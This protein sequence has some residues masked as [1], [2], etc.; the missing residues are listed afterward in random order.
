MTRRRSSVLHRS[1]VL[2]MGLLLVLAGCQP[3]PAAPAGSSQAQK[4]EV[5]VKPAAPAAPA[6]PAKEKVLV[7]AQPGDVT[8]MDANMHNNGPS[9]NVHMNIFDWVVVRMPDGSIQP[10]L[11]ES[12]EN[13]DPLTWV[14]KIRK[15]VKFHNGF[16]LTAED[17]K[18]T[19]ERI[20]DPANKSPRASNW[21]QVDKI[22][23]P[24]PYTFV[25][26]TKAPYALTLARMSGSFDVV[27]KRYHEEAGAQK[28][29]D[30]PIGTGPY[31]FKEWIKDQQVVL[32]AFDGY[33]RG[34]P[35]IDRIVFRPIPEASTRIAELLSG[36][37]HLAYDLTMDQAKDL[38]RRQGV[39]SVIGPSTRIE[40]VALDNTKETPLK[41]VRV[42]Q[43]LNY[44]VDKEG[45]LKA[46]FEGQG[47]AVGQPLTPPIFGYNP[48]VAPYPYDPDKAK[49][50]LAQAGHPSGF[51]IDFECNVAEKEICEAL[52]LQLA[53]VGVN[54][55]LQVFDNTVYSQRFNARQ[56]GPMFF[57]TWLGTTA[58]AEGTLTPRLVTGGRNSHFSDPEVDQQ[59]KAGAATLVEAERKKV[60]LPLMQELKDKAPW[61][62]L[63]QGV[64]VYAV[65]QKLGGWTPR[66]DSYVL[67]REATLAD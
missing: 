62:Y 22:E 13:P 7:M 29:I 47:K 60:Y 25:V 17:L 10:A 39:K 27:S 55:K 40:F 37:V 15:G 61:L 65:S 53:K 31:K 23:V 20:L 28:A 43:A 49:Q 59:I 58:D 19:M 56:V 42:R 6:A 46:F 57:N 50:L 3:A 1:A 51:T 33:W 26:R 41:D 52:A 34:R 66:P 2:L 8:T 21:P 64:D 54:A 4:A 11:A 63:W 67:L 24:D 30:H 18:F 48:D 45:L 38:E 44:G 35:K 16:D 36:N 32:E 12:W 14:F 5:A 9:R